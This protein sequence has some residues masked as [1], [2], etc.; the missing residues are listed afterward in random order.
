VTCPPLPLYTVPD[1]PVRIALVPITTLALIPACLFV[2]AATRW[3]APATTLV[4]LSLPTAW[5]ALR[6]GRGVATSV[7]LISV[8]GC[9]VETVWAWHTGRPHDPGLSILAGGVLLAL[10]GVLQGMNGGDAET[11]TAPEAVPHSAWPRMSRTLESSG[12]LPA[13]GRFDIDPAEFTSLLLA[14]QEVARRIAGDLDLQTLPE[15]I[16]STGAN[17]LDARDC[18][19]YWWQQAS[20]V[21]VPRA[22]SSG[23]PCAEPEDRGVWRWVIAQRKIAVRGE[24]GQDE[25]L[26][27]LFNADPTGPDAVVPLI[28]GGELLGLLT[29]HELQCDAPVRFGETPSA[30]GRVDERPGE[31]S[32]DKPGQS[33]PGVSKVTESG[34]YRMIRR[35]AE[36]AINRHARI[37]HLLS[38]VGHLS[39]LA[40]KNALLFRRI[41][42]MATRDGLT[43]LRTHANFHEELAERVEAARTARA[44]LSVM[45]ADIDAFKHFND[46]HGHQ[47]GDE[48]LRE[49]A[50]IWTTILPAE[51]VIGRYGGEE[52]VCV[53]PGY[54]L[55]RAAE[56]A[57]SLRAQIELHPF[58]HAGLDLRVT[59]SFGVA[60]LP[61]PETTGEQLVA[62]AD[63]ALYEAKRAGRN[64]VREAPTAA[65]P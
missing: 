5:A 31:E 25:S 35:G 4:V 3:T 26:K 15:T 53:L 62:L 55:R 57:E 1:R 49:T 61:G 41:E 65:K 23:G 10:S 32:V 46:Q 60:E 30:P 24:S 52:F 29:F 59:A 28:V 13:L 18:R 45:I 20:R 56:V 22:A 50:R 17:L 7:G 9:L 21:L 14:L 37:M 42:E 12:T 43:G 58:S 11:E 39:G 34:S 6:S 33:N 36:V 8:A 54:D 19:I 51:A 64:T 44:P 2:G 38:I 48:V 40:L 27:R 47:A 63:K 16:V